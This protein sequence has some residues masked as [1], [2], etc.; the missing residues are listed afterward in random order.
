MNCVGRR[1]I[2]AM[3]LIAVITIIWT[4]LGPLMSWSRKFDDPVPVPKASRY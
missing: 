4:M 2:L 1:T 3:L